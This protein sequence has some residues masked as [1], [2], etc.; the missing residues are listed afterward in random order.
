MCQLISWT[1]YLVTSLNKYMDV[2]RNSNLLVEPVELLQSIVAGSH[3]D[4]E[5]ANA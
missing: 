1:H 2:D 5:L 3:A 4:S